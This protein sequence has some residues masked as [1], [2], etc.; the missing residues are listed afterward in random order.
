MLRFTGENRDSFTQRRRQQAI[1]RILHSA[2]NQ[3]WRLVAT[4]VT[5]VPDVEVV[6]HPHPLDREARSSEKLLQLARGV[7]PKV[8]RVVTFRAYPLE[9]V[10]AEQ[11]LGPLAERHRVGRLK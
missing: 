11:Q 2:Y 4:I 9:R 1:Q 5:S 3:P 6:L 10:N 8:P 7:F